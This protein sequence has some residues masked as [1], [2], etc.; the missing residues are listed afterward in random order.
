MRYVLACALLVATSTVARADD[1]ADCDYLEIAA[2][3]SKAPAIDGE[4]KPL[5]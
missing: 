5:D 1:K 4:L 2:S 3:T